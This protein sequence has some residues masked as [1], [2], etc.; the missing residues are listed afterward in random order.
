MN[1][2]SVDRHLP[3][4]GL[5]VYDVLGTLQLVTVPTSCSLTV[6]NCTFTG[7]YGEIGGAVYAKDISSI[8]IQ[9]S[10]FSNNSGN[11]YAGAVA[12]YFS[13]NFIRSYSSSYS[14]N[15]VRN[16]FQ[17]NAVKGFGSALALG[18]SRTSFRIE[19]NTFNGNFG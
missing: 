18:Y 19:G 1:D 3:C 2:T 12:V 6:L 13:S 17:L 9:N 7:N 4:S 5:L 11:T 10:V 15:I 14:I 8:T 16:L